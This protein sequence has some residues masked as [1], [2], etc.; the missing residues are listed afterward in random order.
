[1]FNPLSR[2]MDYTYEGMEIFVLEKWTASHPAVNGLS[3]H[4]HSSRSQ[5]ND[6]Y[7]IWT[8]T[9]KNLLLSLQ[10]GTCGEVCYWNC[11]LVSHMFVAWFLHTLAY[12]GSSFPS[13]GCQTEIEGTVWCCV[14]DHGKYTSERKQLSTTSQPGPEG[15]WV[16]PE[17]EFCVPSSDYAVLLCAVIFGLSQYY[18]NENSQPAQYSLDMAMRLVRPQNGSYVCGKVNTISFCHKWIHNLTLSSP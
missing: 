13:L 6:W 17:G 5:V 12:C 16:G 10:V 4:L 18:L 3:V 15:C 8:R 2:G 9:F 1:M 14:E 11:V 7:Q